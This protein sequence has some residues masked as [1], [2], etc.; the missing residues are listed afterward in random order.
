[1]GSARDA[2]PAALCEQAGPDDGFWI[3]PSA[4]TVARLCCGKKCSGCD[5]KDSDPDP[6]FPDQLLL[7]GYP[8]MANGAVGGDWCLNCVK[9]FNAKYKTKY[10]TLTKF[11]PHLS[12]HEEEFGI[13]R[14]VVIQKVKDTG[15]TDV[16]ISNGAADA[17]FALQKQRVS[18]K[19][20]ASAMV[21]APQDEVWGADAYIQE[22]GHWTTNGRGHAH[23]IPTSRSGTYQRVRS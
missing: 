6:C 11:K 7:W 2:V 22:F 5:G 8:P 1:M 3:R 16:R 4:K 13:W 12:E 17:E 10:G 9:V 18:H 19:R 14:G 20:K 21:L 15:R 23:G